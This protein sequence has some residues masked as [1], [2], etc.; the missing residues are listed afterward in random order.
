M[1]SIESMILSK[2]T[3]SIQIK[4]KIVFKINN[5]YVYLQGPNYHNKAFLILIL[6]FIQSCKVVIL[7]II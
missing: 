3:R 1:C 5:M 4:L 7:D 2:Q 6:V